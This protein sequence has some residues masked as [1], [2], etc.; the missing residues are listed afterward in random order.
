MATCPNPACRE[1]FVPS[2]DQTVCDECGHS[3]AQPLAASRSEENAVVAPSTDPMAVAGGVT[4]GVASGR[5]IGVGDGNTA[6]RD[7][8]IQN[9]VQQQFCFIG[10]EN[11]IGDRMFRCPSCN[12]GPLCD[13]HFDEP[14]KQCELCVEKQNIACSLCGD[15]IPS[16][17][18]FTC[19]R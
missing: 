14:R 5:T 7:V 17:Q 4:G 15:R 19:T 18:T 13:Q 8:V 16:D 12:R 2:P 9:T 3:I 1:E 10:G 6:G 11:I